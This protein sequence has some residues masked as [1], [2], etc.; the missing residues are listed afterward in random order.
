MESICTI[1][2][3]EYS[4]EES[5][6]SLLVDGLGVQLDHCIKANLIRQLQDRARTSNNRL[7][8]SQFIDVCEKLIDLHKS[9]YPSSYEN[10]SGDVSYSVIYDPPPSP[11]SI[12]QPEE[13][14]ELLL[15]PTIESNILNTSFPNY[16]AIYSGK[17]SINIP[18][19]S[20]SDGTVGDEGNILLKRAS[21]QSLAS[22]DES[23][24]FS[25]KGYATDTSSIEDG[26]GFSEDLEAI[27]DAINEEY[28]MCEKAVTKDVVL[29]D[30]ATEN[31]K[32]PFNS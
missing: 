5:V 6:F 7:F 13:S 28:S 18:S 30:N 16:D 32:L 15:S 26:G 1:D 25:L 24:R 2:D 17:A 27:M 21:R 11:K 19:S 9:N 29:I 22:E 8:S 31:N 12:P 4:K 14:L 23:G 20:P 10:S 3:V